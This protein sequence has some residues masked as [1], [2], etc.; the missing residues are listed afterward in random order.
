MTKPGSHVLSDHE[1]YVRQ[2]Q[3]GNIKL[4]QRSTIARAGSHTEVERMKLRVAEQARWSA[5]DA[6]AAQQAQTAANI[7]ALNE[8]KALLEAE[9]AKKAGKRDKK[10][11]KSKKS[12]APNRMKT[13]CKK[14][15]LLWEELP[16]KKS[17]KKQLKAFGI[18]RNSKS[19][20]GSHRMLISL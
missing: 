14:M 9:R 1:A 7:A 16:T 3:L 12:S 2:I 6:Q 15:V 19:A 18:R 4:R 8:R 17:L 20:N 11:Q 13:L 5:I 10:K